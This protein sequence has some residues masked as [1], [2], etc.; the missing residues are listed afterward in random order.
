MGGEVVW[1]TF[2]LSFT[3]IVH[4]TSPPPVLSHSSHG[5][6]SCDTIKHHPDKYHGGLGGT[7]YAKRNPWTLHCTHIELTSLIAATF[8][9]IYPI[10]TPT[11]STSIPEYSITLYCFSVSLCKISTP[12]YQ[13]HNINSHNINSPTI[14]IPPYRCPTLVPRA[15]TVPF[16]MQEIC[17]RV[18]RWSC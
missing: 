1:G 3:D 5:S 13:L 9:Q 16:V 2:S 11:I 6:S 8:L 14:S 15:T 4:Y 12:Q 17:Q 18:G 10:S 7:C